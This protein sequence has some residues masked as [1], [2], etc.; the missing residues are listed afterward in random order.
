MTKQFKFIIMALLLTAAISVGPYSFTSAANIEIRSDHMS[1]GDE[2]TITLPN[3]AGRLEA[4]ITTGMP[5]VVQLGYDNQNIEE[6]RGYVAEIMPK[7]PFQIRCEDGLY[8]LKRTE[9][10]GGAGVSYKSIT[11]SRLLT[12]ILSGTPTEISTRIPYVNLSPFRIDRGVTVAQAL[13]KLKEDYL[14]T[15]YFRGDKLFVGLPYTE[16]STT[17]SQSDI[18][19]G[20]YAKYSFDANVIETDLLYRKTEDVR[21]KARAISILPDNSRLEAEVGDPEGETR[22]LFYRNIRDKNSLKSLAEEDLKKY[23]YEGYRGSFTTFGIPRIIHGGTAELNDPKYGE[24][25]SGKYLVE[26]IN[27]SWGVNGFRR[28]IT[29]S[30]KVA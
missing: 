18:D 1:L 19:A 14:L 23:R 26:R 4:T 24:A 16:F 3:L 5:V 25:R 6:F 28:E 11:L 29:L 2:C 27:T 17:G 30:R 7:T 12:D 8:N 20:R 15:A 21:L 10:N 13:E 9:V 22:T